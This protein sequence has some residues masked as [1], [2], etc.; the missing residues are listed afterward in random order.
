MKQSGLA[1]AL[2]TAAAIGLGV[3]AR[4]ASISNIGFENG[5]TGWTD[6][7]FYNAGGPPA[8]AP[9]YSTYLA[10]ANSASSLPALSSNGAISVQNSNFDSAAPPPGTISPLCGSFMGMIS[11]YNSAGDACGAALGSCV[12]GSQFSQTFTVPVGALSLSLAARLLTNDGSPSGA[13]DFGGIALLSGNTILSDYTIATY[14]GTVNPSTG[15]ANQNTTDLLAAGGFSNSTNW[16]NPTINLA[17]YAGTDVTLV[18]YVL[19]GPDPAGG[20]ETFGETRLLLDADAANSLSVAP[21]P[22]T[23]Q[24]FSLGLGVLALFSLR[25]RGFRLGPGLRALM[26]F[27]MLLALGTRAMDAQMLIRQQNMNV[28]ANAAALS[29]DGTTMIL[30]N[31][32]S[33]GLKTTEGSFGIYTLVN[34]AYQLQTSSLFIQPTYGSTCSTSAQVGHAVALSADGKTALVSGTLDNDCTGAVWVFVPA[35]NGTWTQQAKLVIPDSMGLP[36]PGEEFGFAVALSSDG[37]TALVSATESG[38]SALGQAYVFVRSGTTWTPQATLPFAGASLSYP[39]IFL[40]GTSLSLSGDGNTAVVSSPHDYGDSGAMWIFTRSGT[41]WTQLDKITPYVDGDVFVTFFNARNA[42]TTNYQFGWSVAIS[43]DGKTIAIS[44]ILGGMVFYKLNAAGSWAFDSSQTSG[45]GQIVL[46]GDGSNIFSV[47]NTG[48]ATSHY[49]R[50]A[51]GKWYYVP[52]D[53]NAGAIAVSSD[54]HTAVLAADPVNFNTADTFVLGQ[55]Y[56]VLSAPATVAVGQ[57]FTLGVNLGIGTL[58][59]VY[60]GYSGDLHFTTSDTG[61][62]VSLPKDQLASFPILSTTSSAT[63]TLSLNGGGATVLTTSGVQTLT[64]VDLLQPLTKGSTTVKVVSPAQTITIT[65]PGPQILGGPPIAIPATSTSGLAVTE[66]STTPAV[67]SVLS[68]GT[69]G[70]LTGGTCA[71]HASQPGDNFYSAASADISFPVLVPITIASS[72]TGVN[73]T[74]DGTTFAT[75]KTVNL[76]AAST[77]TLAAVASVNTATAQTSF[78]S[79]SQGGSM[80]Q[81]LSVPATAT[82]YTANYTTKFLL[83]TTPQTGGSISPATGFFDAGSSVVVTATAVSPAVFAGFSG[84]LTGTTN[85]QTVLMSAPRSVTALFASTLQTVTEISP[86]TQTLG[87]PGPVVVAGSS[88]SGLPVTF[89]TNTP[90][91]CTVNANSGVVALLKGGVCTILGSQAGN[92]TYIPA[93][94]AI[95]FNV[96]VPATLQTSPPGLLL[97]V[98]GSVVSAPKTVNLMPGAAVT[99]SAA[100]SQQGSANVLYVFQSWSPAVTGGAITAPSTATTYTAQYQVQYRLTTSASQGGS[101]TPASA[102]YPAGTLVPV[103]ATAQSGYNFGGFTGDLTGTTTPQTLVMSAA[104][105]VNANFSRTTQAGNVT[106]TSNVPGVQVTVDGALT[107]T[108]STFSWPPGTSHVLAAPASVPGSPGI[109]YVNPKWNVGSGGGTVSGIPGTSGSATYTVTYAT[110]YL[111]TTQVTGNGSVSP[112]GGWFNSGTAVQVQARAGSGAVFSAWTGDLTGSTGTQTLTMNVPKSVTAAFV[113]AAASANLSGA[114]TAKRNGSSTTERI[115]TATVTSLGAT[116]LTNLKI[117]GVSFTTL[118]GAV[119]V[120]QSPNMT[121]PVSL[122]TLTPGGTSN[123]FDVYM[124]FPQTSASARVQMVLTYQADGGVAG[125]VTFPGSTR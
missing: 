53:F 14:P 90:S 63:G 65:S 83:T 71:I 92:A 59:P 37:N 108:P 12:T 109:Q 3:S 68:D 78:Q 100:A 120:T 58:G 44:T 49:A 15:F 72:P 86:G 96:T 11:T 9:G 18:A 43:A 2:W 57:S 23:I 104:R 125:T 82:T 112:N 33:G 62:G 116:T 79:W 22:A 73:V 13:L 41:T 84:D 77:L 89:S 60:E 54:G 93:S 117:T 29:S 110:Q 122:G 39:Y 27:I 36:Q 106:V 114:L 7:A 67:C 31:E 70:F 61:A 66:T 26:P 64:V 76:A 4:G 80:A 81:S 17:P 10:G 107:S 32:T 24:L 124:T 121:F 87:T 111:L 48:S 75:P 55:P 56:Y 102:Y 85:P 50:R 51:D 21:E 19:N 30:G 74:I 25:A 103:S 5:L 118:S 46:S 28:R 34:G 69:V 45:G 91:V 40:F 35:G 47:T 99:V 95:S 6:S 94:A 101:I 52:Y 97:T 1:L 98:G 88:T 42:S 16:L 38:S 8:G 113:A 123:A 119:T 20:P 105:T 115:W